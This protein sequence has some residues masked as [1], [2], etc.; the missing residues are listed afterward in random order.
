MSMQVARVACSKHL[1]LSV[2]FSLAECRLQIYRLLKEVP[3][4]LQVATS[5]WTLMEK[6]CCLGEEYR[7]F[8]NLIR[9][10]TAALL[11]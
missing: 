5:S 6:S 11:H 8:S 1:K 9:T 3:E 10:Q 7:I 4:F 2:T